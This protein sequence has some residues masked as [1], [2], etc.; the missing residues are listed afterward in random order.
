MGKS[1]PLGKKSFVGFVTIQE[2]KAVLC[3]L[4]RAAM[5]YNPK[6]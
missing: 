4:P 6:I 1:D 3:P 5:D 2:M